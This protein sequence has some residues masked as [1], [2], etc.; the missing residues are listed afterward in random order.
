MTEQ[1][2]EQAKD[3]QP[4]DR[5]PVFPFI[6]L[7]AAVERAKTFEAQYRKHPARVTNAATVWKLSPTSSTMLQTISAL[8]GFGLMMDS[9]AGADRKIELT[10]LA[11]TILK[12]ERTGKREQAIRDAALKP[13]LISEHWEKWGTSRPPDREC[14]S[15][16]HLD[17]GFT[18]EAAARFLRIYDATIAYADLKLSDKIHDE[19][20]VAAEKARVGVGDFIQWESGGVAQFVTPMRVVAKEGHYLFVEGSLTGIPMDEVTIMQAPSEVKT[21]SDPPPGVSASPVKPAPIGARQDVFSLDEGQVVLQWPAKMSAT[22]FED[23]ESWL[24]LQLRKIK[25]GIEQ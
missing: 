23:F 22:S 12:D 5:S 10:E 1:P 20:R 25:R 18:E 17:R 14:L 24:Q 3:K 6:D 8:K 13:R 4:R 15:D 21:P 16:L 9:G 2:K 7:Q 11:Q 19:D